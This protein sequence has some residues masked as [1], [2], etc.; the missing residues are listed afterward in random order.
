MNKHSAWSRVI[1]VFAGALA[2]I[3]SAGAARD[4]ADERVV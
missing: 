3:A 1:G 2:F 4:G